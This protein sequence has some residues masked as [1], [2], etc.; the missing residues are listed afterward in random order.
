MPDVI[1]LVT[2]AALNTK[3]IEVKHK[4]PVANNLLRGKRLWR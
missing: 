1:G 2:S 4:I 3:V